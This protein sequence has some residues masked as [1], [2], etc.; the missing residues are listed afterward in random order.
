MI[1]LSLLKYLEDEGLGK[2]DEDL[3]FQKLTLDKVGV[4]IQDIG[5]DQ[6][7]GMRHSQ[8]Y[9]L[10]SRGTNDVDGY[11]RLKEIVDKLNDSFGV[12]ELPAVPP[13]TTEGY[14]N[15]T[16]MPPSSITNTGLDDNG[17]VIYSCTGTIYY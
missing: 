17:R 6:P 14:S 8:G 7:R 11:R 9:E 10:Y 5:G 1:T 4:Y 16:I 3:F 15:V 2:I 12:C 13:A